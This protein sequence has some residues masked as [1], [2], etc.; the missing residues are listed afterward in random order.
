MSAVPPY[1]T[2]RICEEATSTSVLRRVHVTN[3]R[4]GREEG[5]ADQG[6]RRRGAFASLA[7]KR[8]RTI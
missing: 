3:E 7:S 4:R 8:L 2:D 1:P 6:R 5:G